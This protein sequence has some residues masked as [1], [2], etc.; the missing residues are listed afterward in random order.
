MKEREGQREGRRFSQ[1]PVKISPGGAEAQESSGS[2]LR[3]K[4]RGGLEAQL[5]S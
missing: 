3:C 1:Y 5:A 4:K 2:T